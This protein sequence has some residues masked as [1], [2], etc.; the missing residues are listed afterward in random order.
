M[1]ESAKKCIFGL[2]YVL[3][4]IAFLIVGTNGL[5]QLRDHGLHQQGVFSS[6][7]SIFIFSM[8]V[9]LIFSSDHLKNLIVHRNR[10]SVRAS[11]LI[12]ALLIAA[13]VCCIRFITFPDSLRFFIGIYFSFYGNFI[14]YFAFWYNLI[15]AFRVAAEDI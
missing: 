9:S 2:I 5:N 1:K 14:F 6:W 8:I 11:R 4:C 15:Y 13:F 7:I 10:I 3:V 12:M